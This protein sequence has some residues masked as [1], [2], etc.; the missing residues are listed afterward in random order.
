MYDIANE[1][2]GQDFFAEEM[3]KTT[4]MNIKQIQD[5]LTNHPNRDDVQDISDGYHSFHELYEFR[6]VYNALLF[7]AWAKNYKNEPPGDINRPHYNVHKSRRHHNGEEC[8]GGGWFVVVAMLPHGQITNHYRM[9]DWDLFKI[10]E[11]EKALFPYDGHSSKDVL[12]R[13]TDLIRLGK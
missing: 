9:E 8:F 13:M 1:E 5:L 3:E 2:A 4:A 7:N 12:M 6:K 10:P 11:Y